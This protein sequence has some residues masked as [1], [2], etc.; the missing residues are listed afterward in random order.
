MNSAS[1]S[2]TFRI[3]R[4]NTLL[5]NQPH[6]NVKGLKIKKP[7]VAVMTSELNGSRILL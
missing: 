1:K 7:V 3:K 6:I 5:F 4:Y 2:P